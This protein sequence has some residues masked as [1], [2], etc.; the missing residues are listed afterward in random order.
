[1]FTVS[2]SNRLDNLST[3]AG[4]YVYRHTL[5]CCKLLHF[6][7]FPKAISRSRKTI[8][9]FAAGRKNRFDLNF[10]SKQTILCT[11]AELTLI[12]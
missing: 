1:M 5:V 12:L 4:D 10:M 11:A 9:N 6:L 8:L 7:R 3:G 2:V